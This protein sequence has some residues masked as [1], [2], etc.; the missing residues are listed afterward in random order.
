MSKKIAFLFPGQGAQ[1]VGMAKDFYDS[2]SVAREVFEEA[3][4]RLKEPLSR[5]IFEG[6]KEELTLTRNSQCAIYVSS[7]AIWRVIQKQFPDLIPNYCAGLSLGEYTALTASGKLT[8]TDTL[9]LVRLRAQAM[10]EACESRPGTMQVVLGLESSA[11]QEAIGALNPPHLVWVA[12]LNCPG[13]VVISGTL[14]GIHSALEKLKEM[15]ARR[16]LPLDVSGAFHSGL[17]Q[18]AKEKLAPYILSASLKESE[19]LLVMN[20]SGKAER[21][22]GNIC[23]H[24]IDQVTNPVLWES[25]IRTIESLGV[26]LFIEIGCGKTL[27]GLNKKIGTAVPTISVEKIFE[28]EELEERVYGTIIKK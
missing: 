24:L 13:Q 8:F 7:I 16:F 1:Y 26:D 14:D 2:F 22:V 19:P 17:M 21:E 9:S 20:V 5:L 18:E 3:D 4:D 10:Q 27:Q 6:P 23:R 15:G 28:L 11:V 12:N 25:G